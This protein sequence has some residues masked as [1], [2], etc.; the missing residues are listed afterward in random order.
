MMEACSDTVRTIS[1]LRSILTSPQLDAT[2][3]M[4]SVVP[5][6]QTIS[7]GSLAWI[8][9]AQTNT[10]KSR[11]HD[12]R[13]RG[14]A[15]WLLLLFSLPTKRNSERVEVWRKLRR[16]GALP[17]G[18]PGYVLP[19]S[20]LNGEHFQW[21]AAAIRGYKGKASVI[22]VQAIDHVSSEQ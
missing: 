7:D 13:E 15:D 22:K 19:N 21:L 8:K 14:E 1:S 9:L 16:V 18:P 20:G 17:L 3:L 2:T 11:D 10:R 6:A 12:G 4:P 5:R